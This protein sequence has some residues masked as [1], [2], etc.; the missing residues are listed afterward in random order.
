MTTRTQSYSYLWY[1]FFRAPHYNAGRPPMWP[2]HAMR[3]NPTPRPGTVR[4]M[5]LPLAMR[6]KCMRLQWFDNHQRKDETV[7]I[8]PS[9]TTP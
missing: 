5:P 1:E 2:A 9:T 7:E 3:G 8:S 6:K 4:G